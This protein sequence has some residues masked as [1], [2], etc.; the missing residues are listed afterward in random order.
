MDISVIVI[1]YN[2]KDYIKDT[3]KGIINQEFEGNFEIIIHDDASKD[4][5]QDIL[6][7][8][9]KNNPNINIKLILEKENHYKNGEKIFMK[10][11]K[12]ASGKYVAFCEGDDYW[13][14]KNKLQIQYNYME[15]NTKCGYLVHSAKML[16]Y[17]NNNIKEKNF[18]SFVCDFRFELK[19][20]LEKG[21]V[22][23][24]ASIFTKRSILI[25]E[26]SFYTEAPVEDEPIKLLCLLNGYGYYMNQKMCVYRKN[27]NGSWNKTIKGNKEKRISMHNKKIQMYEEFNLYSNKKFEDSVMKA[28]K[29]EKFNIIMA[30]KNYKELNKEEYSDIFKLFPKSTF[31][32]LKF[33]SHYTLVYITLLK[34]YEK[35]YSRLG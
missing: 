19:D 1:T 28:I 27:H 4:G 9:K 5:T 24:T 33:A 26:P 2:H 11:I 30:N 16:L 18:E 17:K 10:T 34:I 6:I 7:E 21:L 35:I 25:N 12:H 32:R 3:L 13:I 22:F 29:I 23:P 31:F 8:Y 20:T 15:N 14:S